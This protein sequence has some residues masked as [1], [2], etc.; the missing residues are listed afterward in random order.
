MKIDNQECWLYTRTINKDGYS[1]ISI[2]GKHEAVHRVSYKLFKGLIP[3]GLQI[4]HLCRVRNCFNPNH[5]EA[6]T[7]RVNSMRGYSPSA[8][9]ARKTKCKNGHEFNQLHISGRKC[10]IC[11][12]RRAKEQYTKPASR[13]AKL[14]SR[15]AHYKREAENIKIKK[16]YK[17]LT[18]DQEHMWKV[19]R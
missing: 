7:P 4:D 12:T 11:V 17:L 6:V 19:A 10:S 1:A 3:K 2:K 13:E 14:V 8:L 18:Q 9:N 5:L 16:L 15:K